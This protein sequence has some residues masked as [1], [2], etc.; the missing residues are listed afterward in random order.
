MVTR[1]RGPAPKL[2]EGLGKS[3][4]GPKVVVPGD[5]Q[6]KRWPIPDGDWCEQSVRWW[7]AATSSVASQVAWTEEDRPKIERML[8][9]VDTWWRL[10]RS[11]PEAAMRMADVVRREEA[12]L[13]LGPAER[14][15]AGL[16]VPDKAD[17]ADATPK[18]SSARSRLR[19]VSD[20][21]G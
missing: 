20:A 6:P 5:G 14:A 18:P 16:V 1:G 11:N 4:G 8:W 21:V 9:L 10:T 17:E 12:S 15:R 13:Y 7:E 3:R 2:G 19:S